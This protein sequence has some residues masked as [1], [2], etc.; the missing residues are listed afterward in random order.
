MADPD[1]QSHMDQAVSAGWL[2]IR[3]EFGD[4][5]PGSQGWQGELT[6]ISFKIVR[7]LE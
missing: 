5:D 4:D 7:R 6:G 1:G 2:P 3:S